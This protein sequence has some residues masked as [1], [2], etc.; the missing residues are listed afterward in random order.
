MFKESLMEIFIAVCISNGKYGAIF[1][2]S[3]LVEYVISIEL[4]ERLGIW[5]LF[6]SVFIYC[7]GKGYEIHLCFIDLVERILWF[8]K[9][10]NYVIICNHIKCWSMHF[11]R[12]F[13]LHDV[14]VHLLWVVKYHNFLIF[15]HLLPMTFLV[16]FTIEIRI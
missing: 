6:V 2:S 1:Y 16:W 15:R 3:Y 9:T 4:I 11:D 5:L 8:N 14:C 12:F 10:V 13:R 7:N